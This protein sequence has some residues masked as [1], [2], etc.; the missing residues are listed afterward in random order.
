M[1]RC[2]IASVCVIAGWL[3][4]QACSQAAEPVE[5]Y[6][7]RPIRLITPAAAGGTTDILARL[8]GAKLTEVFRQQIVVDN[9]ASSSGTIAAEITANAP[10]DG[11][12]LLLPYHQHTVNAALNPNL[13]YHA[14]NSFTPVTQLTAA[15][16]LLVVHP[17]TPVKTLKEF[18]DWTK[19]Y[20]GALNYGSGGIGTGGHLG[21]E[22]YNLLTGVKAQHIPYKGGAAVL[23]ALVGG[24]YH[25]NFAGMQAA[26]ALV[27]TGK[28]K[29]LA[30]TTPQRIRSLPDIP[31][32]AESLPG[33][34]VVG[35]YG[36]LA[37]AKMP[38]AILSKLH[39]EFVRALALPDV[40]ERIVADGSEPVGN[41]PQAFREYL[42]ADMAKWQRVVKASGARL[43]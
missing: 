15:G 4:A 29:A 13:P 24:E 14:V 1:R 23:L 33:F 42:L 28:L 7:S 30:V 32:M 22:L 11:Y 6:P 20:K 17:S 12:T 5:A 10:P 31:A 3:L 16:L 19:G 21:G 18:I 35:W 9:R 26:Q 37:P 36:L 38:P 40:R 8:F 25:Y 43:D 27:R 41:T 34:E 2:G 39:A